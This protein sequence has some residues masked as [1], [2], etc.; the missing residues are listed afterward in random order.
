MAEELEERKSWTI[1]LLKKVQTSYEKQANKSHRH[2]KFKGGGPSVVKH[3][4]F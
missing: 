3:K 1:K 2:I 4:R